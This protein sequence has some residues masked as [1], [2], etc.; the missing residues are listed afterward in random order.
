LSELYEK[1]KDF[2]RALEAYRMHIA[3]RDSLFNEENTKK[4]VQLE[5]NYEFEKKQNQVKLEQQKKDALAAAE[6]KRRNMVLYAISAFGLLVFAFAIF[7]YRSFL[8]KKKAN[9]EIT[10]QKEIIELK[11]KEILDSIYYARRIQRSLLPNEKY[12]SRVLN[13]LK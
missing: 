4:A 11:Q 1:Q 2:S 10:E 6:N 13:G 12:I 9:R 8:Q 3:Y 7:A 5:M